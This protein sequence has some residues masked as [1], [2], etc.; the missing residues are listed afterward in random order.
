VLF[1]V[2]KSPFTNNNF[3]SVIGYITAET[4]ILLY[5]DGVYAASTGSSVEEALKELLKETQVYALGPDLSA[6]GIDKIVEGV[7][8][9]DYSGFVELAEEH[10]VTPW[11]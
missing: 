10:N 9:I 1:T 7:K 2:N 6:R 4:P 8:V 5:E 11:I 3:E